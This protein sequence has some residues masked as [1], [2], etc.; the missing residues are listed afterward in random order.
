MQIEIHGYKFGVESGGFGPQAGAEQARDEA[1]GYLWENLNKLKPHTILFLH[2][3]LE[4]FEEGSRMSEVIGEPIKRQAI[5]R[6]ET[7]IHRAVRKATKR[8]RCWE[9]SYVGELPWLSLSAVE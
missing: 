5:R 2:T 7:H 9:Q 3:G 8:W 1:V 4:A 6:A